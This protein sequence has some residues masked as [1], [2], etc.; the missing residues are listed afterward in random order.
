MGYAHGD[1]E[2][3]Y[4]CHGDNIY[5]TQKLARYAIWNNIDLSQLSVVKF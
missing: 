1:L 3:T 4:L 2:F 5:S